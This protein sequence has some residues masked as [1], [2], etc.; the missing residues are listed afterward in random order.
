MKLISSQSTLMTR[1]S[2]T[3]AGSQCITTS[4]N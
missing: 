4:S 3:Y 1:L 2:V